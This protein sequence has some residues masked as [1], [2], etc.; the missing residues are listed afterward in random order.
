MR[1]ELVATS[2]ASTGGPC[3]VNTGQCDKIGLAVL[4]L[5]ALALQPTIFAVSALLDG[6]ESTYF[7]FISSFSKRD[8]HS[9]NCCN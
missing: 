9:Q 1:I 5:A 2:V 3:T 6:P 4:A 7:K 8:R